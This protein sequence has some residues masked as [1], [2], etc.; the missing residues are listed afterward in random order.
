MRRV[1]GFMIA[2]AC[3]KAT[4]PSSR[5]SGFAGRRA[6]FCRSFFNSLLSPFLSRAASPGR[7]FLGRGPGRFDYLAGRAAYGFASDPTRGL[8]FYGV[9]KFGVVHDTIDLDIATEHLD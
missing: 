7:C 2:P 3:R 5:G 9:G 1:L 6:L 8:F 4:R